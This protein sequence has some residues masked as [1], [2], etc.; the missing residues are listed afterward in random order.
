[1]LISKPFIKHKLHLLEKEVIDGNIT[2]GQASDLIM[3][4]FSSIIKADV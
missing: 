1:M 2:P 4:E 3:N